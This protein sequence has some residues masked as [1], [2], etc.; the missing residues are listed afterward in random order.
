M[1]IKD[2]FLTSEQL[3]QINQMIDA[4]ITQHNGGV[5]VGDDA[6]REQAHLGDGAARQSCVCCTWGVVWL[7]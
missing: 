4:D 1:I 2:N 7:L 3:V 5:D 6:Q